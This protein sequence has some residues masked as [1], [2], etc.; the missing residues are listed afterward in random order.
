MGSPGLDT[1]DTAGSVSCLSVVALCAKGRGSFTRTDPGASTQR[2][3]QRRIFNSIL[4]CML[5]DGSRDRASVDNT[6]PFVQSFVSDVKL[7]YAAEQ[8]GAQ[9][10]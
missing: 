9:G 5:L 10:P 2:N 4:Y 8:A 3:F 7:K 1:R 6:M